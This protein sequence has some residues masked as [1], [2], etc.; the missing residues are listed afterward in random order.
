MRNITDSG[1]LNVMKSS[2]YCK[3]FSTVLFFVLLIG[4]SFPLSAKPKME[5]ELLK[6]G[7]SQRI[8][9]FSWGNLS[10]QLTNPDSKPCNIE[11]R[12]VDSL[13][14]T[15]N[16]NTVFSETVYLPPETVIQ[17]NTPVM[18][19]NSD[20]YK[21]EM[22]VDGVEKQK[23]DP[24]FIRLMSG[25]SSYLPILNDSDNLSFGS[26]ATAPEF[27]GIFAVSAFPVETPN[28][29]WSMLKKASSII[30]VRP[31][32]SRYSSD[33]L[34]AILDYVYQGGNIIFADPVG[35]I[36]ASKTPLSVLLPVVPLRIRKITTLEPLHKILPGFKKFAGSVDF[37]ESVSSGN[38]VD[39]LKD[40]DMP[41]FRWKKYGLGTCRFSAVPLTRNSFSNNDTWLKILSMFFAHQSI[42]NDLSTAVPV[43]NEMTGFT[44]PGIESVRKILLIYFI[45]IIIPLG[46]G[47]FLKRT[48]AAWIITG[49][50]T[51]LFS[52][53]ILRT[54]SAGHSDKKGIFVSFIETCIPGVVASPGE[55]WYGIFST[56]DTKISIKTKNTHTLLSAIPPPDNIV[57]MVQGGLSAK[58]SQPTEVKTIHALPEITDLSLNINTARQFFAAYDKTIVANFNLPEL[59]Y[60]KNRFTFQPWKITNKLKPYSA[61]L[62]FANGIIP[63]TVKDNT[64]KADTA[65][66][67]LFASDTTLKS[68]Q[69][70]LQKGWKHSSPALILVENST[71]TMLKLSDEIIVHG[72]KLTVI[73]VKEIGQNRTITIPHQ[74]VLLTPGDTST[75]RVMTGNQI[76][77]S[78]VSRNDLDYIFRYQLPPLFSG[79]KPEK[80]KI[81][82][83]YVNDGANLSIVPVI[84]TGHIRNKKFIKKREIEAVR[85]SNGKFIFEDVAD[86]IESGTGFVALK[87]KIKRKNLPTGERVRVNKWSLD[88]LLISVTG[89]VPWSTSSFTF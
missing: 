1:K 35:V 87:V 43:L 61:W 7:H 19:E 17:Y 24:F 51:V 5:R 8:K 64:V 70:F 48:I 12:F 4:L 55:G 79:I 42:S 69:N 2:K 30:I 14:G 21:I 75:R 88:K 46:L 23:S 18:T 76:K 29:S 62:Q 73:P 13:R 63:L 54:V 40:R 9:R 36:E 52:F 77:P 27:K 20:E 28:F 81:D 38:G 41:V 6:Y 65:T 53:H 37:L 33:K 59:H 32:F 71:K 68:V 11:L 74:S 50:I 57:A 26:F 16:N 3:Q 84:L 58:K 49:C 86:C 15:V 78:I 34:C 31:D 89:V 67:A 45:L 85:H 47:L 44:V 83:K 25:N 22:F 66:A 60:D 82:F 80:I 10:C 56:S 39:F 72:K